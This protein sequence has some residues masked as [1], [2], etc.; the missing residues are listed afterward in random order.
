MRRTGAFPSDRLER[1]EERPL[2]EELGAEDVVGRRAFHLAARLQEPDLQ[3]LA[4]VVPLVDGRRDVQPLVALE[5]D[6]ARVERLGERLGELRSCRRRPRPPPGAG[7]PARGQGRPRW[8]GSGR[9]C[10]PGRGRRPAVPRSWPA[11]RGAR[12]SR[13]SSLA[14]VRVAGIVHRLFRGGRGGRA[15]LFGRNVGWIG[16]PDGLGGRSCRRVGHRAI[17]RH[18]R[19]GH[20]DVDNPGRATHATPRD[21]G[22]GSRSSRVSC[23]MLPSLFTFLGPAGA[24]PGGSWSVRGR[25]RG[26]RSRLGDPATSRAAPRIRGR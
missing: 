4:G 18:R 12:A 8:P 1:L 5:P 25:R 19:P 2:E 13:P 22:R 17:C 7:A 10:S 23:S 16:E 9:Q 21:R 24:A 3:H 15:R 6:E 26:S 20:P 11:R 14:A